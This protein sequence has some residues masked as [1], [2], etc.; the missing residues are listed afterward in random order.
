MSDNQDKQS[1][2]PVG[3]DI[4]D[5]VS[6]AISSVDYER[7]GE[8]I[9]GTVDKA[10]TEAKKGINK[11]RYEVQKQ[12]KAA[13]INAGKAPAQKPMR[14]PMAKTPLGTYSGPLMIAGCVVTV[15]ASA[16][17][18]LV[19]LAFGMGVVA[20]AAALGF[21]ALG[22]YLGASAASVMKRVKRFGVYKKVLHGRAYCETAE[23][24]DATGK[25]KRYTVKDLDKM[26]DKKMFPEGRFSDDDTVL[27]LSD[28]AYDAYETL[29]TGERE[30]A[31]AA[32]EQRRR[33]EE[34]P[35][36]KEVRLVIEEGEASLKE[37]AAA[38]AAIADPAISAKLDR[39]E[40]VVRKIFEFI[41]KNPG[42]VMEMRRF[43]G[44]YLPT[45]LKLVN[46]YKDLEAQPVQGKN[47][48]ESKQEI[49]GTL[50]TISG[51]FEKLLDSFYEDTAMDVTSDIS[52]MKSMF[53][54]DGLSESGLSMQQEDQDEQ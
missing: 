20:Q 23:L 35:V 16:S 48:R 26:I 22:G 2:K 47:I 33:E 40:A 38:N 17:V 12:M 19:A 9:G 5:M 54:Q 32:E 11:G 21:L 50:D 31:R 7:L 37:I 44:Y 41:K 10:I 4:V 45:T 8:M 30:K 49:E 34:N 51:A 27:L 6:K 24:A 42:Q 39:L 28:E 13:S 3:D 15:A 36:Y 14:A 18:A 25:S 46:A 43:M 53:A 29:M 52:V 1:G